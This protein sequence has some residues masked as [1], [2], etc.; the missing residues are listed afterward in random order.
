MKLIITH[1]GKTSEYQPRPDLGIISIGRVEG[2]DIRIPG[3]KAASRKHAT[4]ERTMDGWKLVDQMSSN[5]TALNGDKVNFAFL[6]E[7]DVISIGESTIRVMGLASA[8]AP[9]PMPVR[10]AAPMPRPEAARPMAYVPPRR[11][12]VGAIVALA[13]IGLLLAGA[14]Y[15]I[16]SYS[17]NAVEAPEV[18]QQNSRQAELSVEDQNAI[19]KAKSIAGSGEDTL[20]R[21]RKLD[22]M[23]KEF[24]G[25]RGSMALAE[26]DSLLKGLWRE[27]G[28]EVE[29]RIERTLAT[30]NEQIS[31]GDY[32]AAHTNLLA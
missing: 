23:K 32:L 26:I 7:G 16:F 19:S 18:A 15:F 4:L 3:E 5:G 24:S 8:A 13:L 21:I 10:P 28:T 9:A 27:V 1:A 11:S 29:T 30:S 6:Q 25:K 2:N 12:P 22:Q 31:A 17:G 20:A 14:G